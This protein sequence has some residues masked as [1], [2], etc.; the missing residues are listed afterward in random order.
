MSVQP[1]L[2]CVEFAAA[3]NCRAIPDDEQWF[4]HVAPECPEKFDDL[5]RANGPGK[6][7]KV[8][9]SEGQSSNGRELL[10]GEA[11]PKNRRVVHADSRS[12]L[13]GAVRSSRIRR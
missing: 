12:C 5:L 10:P 13:A 4:F 8:K 3:M 1:L 11:V 2:P 7:A 9:L 6:E